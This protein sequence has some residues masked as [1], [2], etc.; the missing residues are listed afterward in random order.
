MKILKIFKRN[1]DDDFVERVSI[2]ENTDVFIRNF[3]LLVEKADVETIKRMIKLIANSIQG[4]LISKCFYNGRN[5]VMFIR[6]VKKSI[7][8]D[9][10]SENYVKYNE[11]VD[12]ATNPV[13]SC[14]WNGARLISAMSNINI[15]VG[16]PFDGIRNSQNI[17][18][19][20]VKPINLVIVVNGNH[21]VNSAIVHGEGELIVNEVID[22]KPL[23]E[24]YRF[25]GREY[26]DIK[27]NK[28][29]NY[30]LLKNKSEPFVYELGLL[31]EMARILDKKGICLET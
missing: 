22:I 7:L 9:L 25:T 26:V 2:E 10:P 20:M 4:Q 31:F 14:V 16:N 19:Y 23:L 24:K 21:S 11:R 30:K 13:I 18:A 17:I 12:I 5:Y 6:N 1:T 15:F 27:T 3:E 8:I 28:P 29:I